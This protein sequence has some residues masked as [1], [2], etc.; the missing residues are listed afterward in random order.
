M[1]IGSKVAYLKGLADG[2]EISDESKEGKIIK[3]ILEALEDMAEMLETLEE[4]NETLEDYITEVDEDLGQ[5]EKDYEKT[6][7]HKLLAF[8]EE[9]E[10][11]EDFKEFEDFENEEFDENEALDGVLEIKC[12]HCKK[13]VL[14]ETDAILNS[15]SL[16]VECPECAGSISILIDDDS[17]CSCSG[18]GANH[19]KCNHGDD[20]DDE[21]LAF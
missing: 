7:G 13:H 5:L 18:C 3:G 12:P 14:I 9:D 21:D 20:G 16:S 4:E 15:E 2:L 8:E 19:D 11:D 17:G 1:N 6:C 10:E